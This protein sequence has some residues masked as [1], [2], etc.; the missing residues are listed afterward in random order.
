M[1]KI[2]GLERTFKIGLALL[3]ALPMKLNFRKLKMSSPIRNSY[4]YERNWENRAHI[5]NS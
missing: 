3:T 1:G 4:M 2:G 5:L